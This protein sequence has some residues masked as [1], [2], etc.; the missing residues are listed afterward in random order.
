MVI[1]ETTDVGTVKQLA[2]CV[3]FCNNEM[4]TDIDVIDFVECSNGSAVSIFTKLEETLEFLR[5]REVPLRN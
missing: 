5:V 1:D 4:E 3:S 2:V